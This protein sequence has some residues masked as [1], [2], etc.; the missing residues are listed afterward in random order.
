MASSSLAL[1]ATLGPN[2]V[3]LLL[4]VLKEG[5]AGSLLQQFQDVTKRT[6]RDRQPR[7]AGRA[8]RQPSGPARPR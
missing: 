7:Q 5:Y 2:G 3:V 6:R 4:V 8:V 1:G